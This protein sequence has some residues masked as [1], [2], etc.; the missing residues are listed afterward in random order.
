MRSC[1]Q[2]VA[3]TSDGRA[4]IRNDV[5]IWAYIR[6]WQAENLLVTYLNLEAGIERCLMLR[7]NKRAMTGEYRGCKGI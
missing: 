6:G 3:L 5:G 2:L 1:A 7:Q 4:K